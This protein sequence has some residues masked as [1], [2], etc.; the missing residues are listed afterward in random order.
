M[1]ENNDKQSRIDDVKRE[2]QSI[3]LKEKEIELENKKREQSSKKEYTSIL[4]NIVKNIGITKEN[5]LNITNNIILMKNAVVTKLKELSSDITRYMSN[6]WRDIS[7]PIQDFLAPMMAIG[8]TLYKMYK[9]VKKRFDKKDDKGKSLIEYIKDWFAKGLIVL[10]AIVGIGVGLVWNKIKAPVEAL[11]VGIST[12]TKGVEFV[13]SLFKGEGLIAVTIQKF[14][15]MFKSTGILGEMVISL[16]TGFKELSWVKSIGGFFTS[17]TEVFGGLVKIGSKIPMLSSLIKGFGMGFQWINKLFWPIQALWSVYDLVMGIWNSEQ[18]SM[19]GKV[20]DGLKNM[21]SSFL[22]P[23]IRVID[24]FTG[25]W[26]SDAII[27]PI[28]KLF[29][30]N[31]IMELLRSSVDMI[32]LLPQSAKEKIKG[33]FTGSSS[34]STSTIPTSAK[35]EFIRK[36]RAGGTSMGSMTPASPSISSPADA[37]MTSASSTSLTGGATN[38]NTGNVYQPSQEAKKWFND[39]QETQRLLREWLMS[40]GG[41]GGG[42]SISSTNVNQKTSSNKE[43]GIGP[44]NIPSDIENLGILLLNKSWGLS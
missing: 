16:T 29:D 9:M 12:I 14:L 28:A 38:V 39:M 32:P 33:W 27:K 21:V 37:G 43:R 6:M 11:K 34:S 24:F 15:G 5:I 31:N 23:F 4:S 30:T 18:G 7:R 1:A 2:I 17:I 3:L 42:N 8:A 10:G 22:D 40:G 44:N 19:V 36:E 26:F 35:D 20:I 13:G 41:K 25:G